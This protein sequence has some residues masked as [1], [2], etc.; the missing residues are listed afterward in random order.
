MTT[1]AKKKVLLYHLIKKAVHK[2]R[3]K[4][5]ENS[6]QV[7]VDDAVRIALQ[8]MQLRDAVRRALMANPELNRAA[9]ELLLAK[10]EIRSDIADL[11][12]NYA[13]EFMQ[14]PH[15]SST[16]ARN[17][18]KNMTHFKDITNLRNY[19]ARDLANFLFPLL[20]LGRF[21]PFKDFLPN[22]ELPMPNVPPPSSK[23]K[24]L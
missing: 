10:P 7:K 4:K 19:G 18:Y 23:F 5:A 16:L 6:E 20:F 24:N 22:E 12:A 21:A 14:N 15:A 13:S 9:Q 1:D 2:V 8:G 17:I 3:T 11:V